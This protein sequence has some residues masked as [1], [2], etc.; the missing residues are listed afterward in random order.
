MSER[1]PD[2][3]PDRNR[4][5]SDE[6]PDSGASDRSSG[7]G[8][9][10]FIG[11]TAGGAVAT[12]VPASTAVAAEDDR[13]VTLV[14]DTHFHGRFRD[15][16]A[17]ELNIQRYYTVVEEKLEEYDNAVFVGIGD[18]FA[19]SLLGLEYEGEHMVE[20]LN[21]M[22][23]AV[24]GVGNHEFDF[25]PDRAIELFGE[26]EFPWV[27]ANLLDDGGETLENTERWTTQE[28]GDLTVGFFGMVSEN[29]HN[30]TDYPDDWQVLDNVDAGQE[31]VDELREEG[32]DIVVC[33]AHVSTGTHERMA[34]NI[35][36]LDAIVGSHS[37]VVL[38]QPAEIDGTINAE[39]GD[40][41]DHIGAITLNDEGE[42][43]D[44]ERIDLLAEDWE[45]RDEV[46][47]FDEISTR[48]VGEIEKHEALDE[49]YEKYQV[50]L[51]DRLGEPFFHSETELNWSFDNYAIET[52]GGNVITDAIREVGDVADVDVDIGI[53]NGGG[54]R[55]DTTFGPGEITGAAVMEALPFPN[56]LWIIEV[57]G[58]ELQD[59]L[60]NEQR[61]HP[62]E[63]FG[64]QP[65]IQ[66]SGVSYEWWGHDWESEIRNVF[67]GGDP[68]DEDETYLLAGTDFQIEREDALDHE[69]KLIAETGQF[70]GP[71]VLDTLEEWGTVA[72]E[73]E[74]RM[75]RWDEDVGEADLAPGAD[76][77]EVTFEVPPGAEEIE[78]DEPV[79]AVNRDGET[80][81][82]EAVSADGEAVTA[83]FA[84]TPLLDLAAV[85]DPAIRVFAHYHAD[86]AEWPYDFD[87]PTSDGYD[88]L[89]VRADVDE[90]DLGD[91]TPAERTRL[92]RE[93][94]AALDLHRGTE[95][96]L[97]STLE[98]AANSFDRA[99]ETAAANRL[100][101]FI[102]QVEAQRGKKIDEADAD[103]LIERAEEIIA[104]V[105]EEC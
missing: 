33:P 61:A 78:T 99:N 87:I 51:D 24:N 28:L 31:A 89:K 96:S 70:V 60:A 12:M 43:V 19:P 44:W 90:D 81:E 74:Y 3:D 84:T 40:E 97:T 16:E 65:A 9:R 79:V 98:N 27:V 37:G 39:F 66:I 34:E 92:V 83:S 104:A 45:P 57:T 7:I 63:Q 82:A 21:A 71:F 100:C 93:R 25:G 46:D 95:N 32:A 13:T 17:A 91:F 86:Q 69:N 73:R 103:D 29:F 41:F 56:E 42:L 14:F 8:R 85:E 76:R 77:T 48:N 49:L 53:I 58:E 5:G 80:V 20:A 11:A 62:S 59:F 94:V 35:D 105:G 52:G 38:D 75:I 15:S 88:H 101:A 68:V 55:A 102:N 47:E 22:D 50:P 72:P 54:I 64:T 36:G 67:V 1:H 30:I 4:R 10:R 23:V 26:S 6:S 18:D 2:G